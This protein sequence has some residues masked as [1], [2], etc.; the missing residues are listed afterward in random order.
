MVLGEFG[1]IAAGG[2]FGA[3]MRFWVSGGVYACWILVTFD[4]NAGDSTGIC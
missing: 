2:A 3:I 1:A 4:A